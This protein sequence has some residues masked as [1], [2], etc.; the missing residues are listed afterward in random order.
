MPA[1]DP[2]TC[3]VL[4]LGQPLGLASRP[5]QPLQDISLIQV[6]DLLLHQYPASPVEAIDDPMLWEAG[7]P[8]GS[9]TIPRPTMME[10]AAGPG[11]IL[12]LGGPALVDGPALVEGRDEA[13]LE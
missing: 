8:S 13:I 12:G 6:E 3:D 7:L 4:L 9:C 2:M 11:C 5:R 10:D 1:F